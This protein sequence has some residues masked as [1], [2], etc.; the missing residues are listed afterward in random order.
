MRH[1]VWMIVRHFSAVCRTNVFF[2]RVVTD[3][4]HDVRVESIP[5][6]VSNRFGALLGPFTRRICSV[7]PSKYVGAR[8]ERYRLP[9]CERTC[10]LTKGCCGDDEN[11][12]RLGVHERSV[13]NRPPGP[14]RL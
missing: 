12:A 10:A 14:A 3:P 5:L 7:Y 8:N 6:I 11:V 13:E 9:T 2:A 4:Q 1:F